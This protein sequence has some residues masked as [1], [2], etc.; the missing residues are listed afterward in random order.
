[1][2]ARQLQLKLLHLLAFA[3]TISGP[4]YHCNTPSSCAL[5]HRACAAWIDQITISRA[6]NFTCPVRHGLVYTVPRWQPTGPGAS[7]SVPETGPQ[8]ATQWHN[9]VQSHAQAGSQTDEPM[10]EPAGSS[11]ADEPMP[12]AAGSSQSHDAMQSQTQTNR[13]K[14]PTQSQTQTSQLNSPTQS[15]TQG[16][17][18]LQDSMQSQAQASS[19][20]QHAEQSQPQG[21]SP[22]QEP[23]QS[24]TQASS[25][26]PEQQQELGLQKKASQ[27]KANSSS[28]QGAGQTP[29][30][31]S[32]MAQL[33]VQIALAACHLVQDL[34]PV[35]G[36][37]VH[38]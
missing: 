12:E 38:M 14:S 30:T 26:S 34:R 24:Q 35:A 37:H 3:T 9:F 7:S 1:M 8:L 10:T 4:E 11:Q 25:Q 19:Q 15:Q 31:M 18:P 5:R 17:S 2:S 28:P 33:Q 21:S 29:E 23:M 16:S 6:G 20:S 27:Q 36:V 13:L 32:H 22:L